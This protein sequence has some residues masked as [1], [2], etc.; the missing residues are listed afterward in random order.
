MIGPASLGS[1]M[2]ERGLFATP[3]PTHRDVLR[4][5]G[6]QVTLKILSGGRAF[7]YL[8]FKTRLIHLSWQYVE[9]YDPLSFSGLAHGSVWKSFAHYNFEALP[10]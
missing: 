8:H 4:T 9:S 5:L 6:P 2:E 10:V 3:S 1:F 7:S